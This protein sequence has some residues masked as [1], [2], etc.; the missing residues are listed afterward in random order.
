M[1]HQ[2]FSLQFI[3]QYLRNLKTIFSIIVLGFIAV[4]F[5]Q[6]LLAIA[7]NEFISKGMIFMGQFLD[8]YH[9]DCVVLYT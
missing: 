3:F 8:Q 9:W 2:W 1:Y 5:G 6:N 7:Y 4:Y